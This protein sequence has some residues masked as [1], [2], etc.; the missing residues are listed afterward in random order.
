LSLVLNTIADECVF[1]VGTPAH[2]LS[3]GLHKGLCHIP[4]NLLNDGIYKISMMIVGG[5]SY[6]IYYY[7]DILNFEVNENRE[8]SGWHGKWIGIVRPKLDFTL[9]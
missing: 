5:K 1:N 7:Q 9:E 3:K 6:S 8:S 2:Y 4:A